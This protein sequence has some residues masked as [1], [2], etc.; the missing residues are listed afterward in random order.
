M[1]VRTNEEDIYNPVSGRVSGVYMT[2]EDGTEKVTAM[3]W[4]GEDNK[5]FTDKCRSWMHQYKWRDQDFLLTAYPKTG[6]EA[7]I[8]D[9][10]QTYNYNAL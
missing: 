6:E 3:K 9:V 1:A 8:G 10:T 2:S 5:E 7:Q 4:F